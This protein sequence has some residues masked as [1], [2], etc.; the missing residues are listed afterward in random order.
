MLE[1]CEP[2]EDDNE[3]TT[4]LA[5]GCAVHRSNGK[6]QERDELDARKDW[7]G[8]TEGG[9]ALQILLRNVSRIPPRRMCQPYALTAESKPTGANRARGHPLRSKVTSNLCSAMNFAEGPGAGV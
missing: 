1:P 9:D 3:H 8:S 7:D 6:G 5:M 2:R 4:M